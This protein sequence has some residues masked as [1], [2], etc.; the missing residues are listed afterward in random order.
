[1]PSA[2]SR[3]RENVSSSRKSRAKAQFLRKLRN[4]CGL[5]SL[6]IDHGLRITIDGMHVPWDHPC[7]DGP[8]ESTLPSPLSDDALRRPGAALTQGDCGRQLHACATG[9]CLA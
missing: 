2:D 9:G 7:C 8:S 5:I 3:S 4:K 1:M 6:G